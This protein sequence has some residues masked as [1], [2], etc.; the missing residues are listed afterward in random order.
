MVRAWS[1]AFE[2]KFLPPP[3]QPKLNDS[4]YR[5]YNSEDVGFAAQ[6]LYIAETSTGSDHS[7]LGPMD[8]LNE[9]P[10]R[11]LLPT[12]SSTGKL[13]HVFHGVLR[14]VTPDIATSALSSA[15]FLRSVRMVADSGGI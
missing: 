13:S 2:G 4:L 1:T 12:S 11:H 9:H 6:P 15:H 8:R 3:F 10:N 14:R 7:A 5:D